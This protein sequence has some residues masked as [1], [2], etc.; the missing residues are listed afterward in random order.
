MRIQILESIWSLENHRKFILT[1]KIMKLVWSH[2]SEF[3]KVKQIFYEISKIKSD[4]SVFNCI[5]FYV[6]IILITFE[7]LFLCFFG[8]F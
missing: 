6:K 5:I 1:Q 4:F 8:Y 2:I 7:D 3:F